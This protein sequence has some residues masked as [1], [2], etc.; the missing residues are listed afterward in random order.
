VPPPRWQTAAAPPR[1]RRRAPRRFRRGPTGHS[2]RCA[3]SSATPETA[4][5]RRTRGS[6]DGPDASGGR[7]TWPSPRPCRVAPGRVAAV[8]RVR[9]REARDAGCDRRDAQRHRRLRRSEHQRPAAAVADAGEDCRLR[10]GGL[11]DGA[12]VLH[13]LPV[14]VGL[15]GVRPVRPPVTP[16]VERDDAKVTREVR[17]LRLPQPR[18]RDGRRREEQERRRPVAVDLVEDPNAVALDA[19]LFVGIAGA[20]LLSRVRCDDH[21]RPPDGLKTP[22]TG[23]PGPSSSLAP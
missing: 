13:E 9:R 21:G 1:P 12:T 18:V 3:S 16:S 4:R 20:R 2:L 7:S 11:E 22:P 8:V 15:G 10:S 14:R 5:R 6:R 17:D 19:A 23:V